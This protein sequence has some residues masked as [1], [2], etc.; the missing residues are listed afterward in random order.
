MPK[1]DDIHK[2]L[3]IGSGPIVIGQAAEFD[4]SGTQACKALR[5]MGYKI[6]L[7]NSNPA[8][9]MTDPGMADRTYI[10]PLNSGMLEKIIE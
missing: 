4:Y 3:I 1:R 9:I 2:V 10:E 8:T 6:V 5:Q 7:V